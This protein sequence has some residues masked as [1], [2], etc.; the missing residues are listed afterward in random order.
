M[1]ND[2]RKAFFKVSFVNSIRRL[3]RL[4]D[5]NSPDIITANEIVMAYERAKLA[6][7][8]E[9]G[10][11]IVEYGR[12]DKLRGN[13]FCPYCDNDLNPND[14]DMCKTCTTDVEELAND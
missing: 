1:M 7:P 12:T 6:M 3:S 2:K 9:M 5:L 4:I 13:G 11:A 8:D 10:K 14:R